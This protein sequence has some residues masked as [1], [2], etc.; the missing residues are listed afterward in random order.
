[1]LDF[2]PTQESVIM[3]PLQRGGNRKQQ[4]IVMDDVRLP[5]SEE[6]QYQDNMDQWMQV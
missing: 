6:K 1:L 2:D 4:K 5:G 3:V